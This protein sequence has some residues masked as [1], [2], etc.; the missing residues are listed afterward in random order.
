MSESAI[1]IV[2]G[3]Y[4]LQLRFDFSA[5]ANL[6]PKPMYLT[7]N[8]EGKQLTVENPTGR[9]NQEVN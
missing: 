8:G 5:Q 4:N 9:Q 1:S 7:D 6:P 2:P 3:V